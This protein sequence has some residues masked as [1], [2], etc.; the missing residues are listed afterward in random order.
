MRCF[1][2][3]GVKL[4]S[5][6]LY[7]A[8]HTDDIRV[9]LMYISRLYPH[10][11]LLGLGYS[12]GANVLTRY[13]AEEGKHSRLVAGLALACVSFILLLHTVCIL[14]LEMDSPGILLRTANGWSFLH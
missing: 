13:L 11:P 14:T 8:A 10:A 5:P 3:A 6:Q 4:T 2:G 12:L 1:V 7:S 9:A